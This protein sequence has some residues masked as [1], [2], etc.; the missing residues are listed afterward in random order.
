[1][2]IYSETVADTSKDELDLLIDDVEVFSASHADLEDT[3]GHLYSP[4][5]RPQPYILKDELD[6]LRDDI[7]VFSAPLQI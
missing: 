5:P 7:E 2:Q 4:P 3:A 1:M 6:L